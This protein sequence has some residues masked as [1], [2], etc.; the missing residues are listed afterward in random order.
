VDDLDLM[1]LTAAGACACF[2]QLP[3]PSPSVADSTPHRHQISACAFLTV[4]LRRAMFVPPPAVYRRL[5]TVLKRW[6]HFATWH[7][8]P[9]RTSHALEKVRRPAKATWSWYKASYWARRNTA[10][11]DT[12]SR[13][14]N[15]VCLAASGHICK[16]YVQTF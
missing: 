8:V 2:P 12:Y 11:I 1:K 10:A 13:R 16:F 4:P 9:D 6:H 7:V 14:F 5:R 15:R 3:N